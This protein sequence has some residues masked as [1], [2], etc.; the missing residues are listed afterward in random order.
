MVDSWH[1]ACVNQKQEVK[2]YNSSEILRVLLSPTRKKK[3]EVEITGEQQGNE[4]I[5]MT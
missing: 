2:K 5:L 3:K 4:D 1:S